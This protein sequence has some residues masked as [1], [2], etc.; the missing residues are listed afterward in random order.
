[1][2]I[3]LE[4][5]AT[6]DAAKNSFVCL[7]NLVSESKHVVVLIERYNPNFFHVDLERKEIVFIMNLYYHFFFQNTRSQVPILSCF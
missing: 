5:F 7:Q 3:Y 1:M 2:Y 6:I 4:L